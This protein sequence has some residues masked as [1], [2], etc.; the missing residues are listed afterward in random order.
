MRIGGSV[1]RE[2]GRDGVDDRERGRI[3]LE[4]PLEPR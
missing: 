2:R 3:W 4:Q 1:W